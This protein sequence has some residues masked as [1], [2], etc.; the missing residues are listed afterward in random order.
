[1]STTSA[2]PPFPDGW[3]FLASEKELARGRILT[4]RLAG[5]DVVLARTEA[6]R[7]AAFRPH[8]PHLGA[9]LGHGGKI[10]GEELQCPM[11]H[12][13]FD[14]GGQCVRTPYQ[15]KTPPKAR[16]HP[17]P[18]LERNGL[19][20]VWHSS[21][22][23]KPSWEVPAI[24]SEGFSSL[25]LTTLELNGHPQETSEN[26]V[27]LGHLG[28]LHSFFDVESAGPV[29]FDGPYLRA[30]FSFKRSAGVFGRLDAL[31]ASYTAHVYGLGCSF[32]D[33]SVP[34]FGL[35][36]QQW[37]LAT[38]TDAGRLALT[39]GVRSSTD[40]ASSVHPLLRLVPSRVR[41]EL[42]S[43]LTMIGYRHEVERDVRVWQ[44]KKYLE[45]P[46]LADGDGPIGRYR[47]W[48]RQ[49]YSELGVV[50]TQPS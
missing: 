8:C 30:A 11:H 10:V 50:T 36:T 28:T 15:R 40:S 32:V 3:Y 31:K 45:M 4:R 48:A 23:R 1:M 42:V 34:N 46:A 2:L 14:A 24:D 5:E 29:V 16:L 37:V 18:M 7:A 6:G 22:G 49:F 43:A 12:F 35:R 9:H 38:P 39:L 44:H 47:R 20:F 25:H 19:V 13:C 41:L 33:V 21:H 26:S 17:L 27:D